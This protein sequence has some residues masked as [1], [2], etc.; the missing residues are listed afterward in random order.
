MSADKETGRE[1]IEDLIQGALK[2]YQNN[3]L[4]DAI[5]LLRRRF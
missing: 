4:V 5:T 2:A 3:K 1:R